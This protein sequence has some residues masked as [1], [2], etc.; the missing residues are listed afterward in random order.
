M[1]Q[2]MT[3]DVTEKVPFELVSKVKFSLELVLEILLQNN[4]LHFHKHL[5]HFVFI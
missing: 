3:A 5:E 1:H 4:P 2:L